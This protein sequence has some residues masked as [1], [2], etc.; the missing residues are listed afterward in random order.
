MG[1]HPFS[2]GHFDTESEDSQG[3]TRGDAPRHGVRPEV[4][5]GEVESGSNVYG[6]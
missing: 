1:G 5:K 4:G 6:I 3:F 2:N